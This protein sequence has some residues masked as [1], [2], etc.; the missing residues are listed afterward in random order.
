MRPHHILLP[1]YNY[2][3][4]ASF[5]LSWVFLMV[6]SVPTQTSS[7]QIRSKELPFHHVW[8]HGGCRQ[9]EGYFTKNSRWKYLSTP[10]SATSW[11]YWNSEMALNRSPGPHQVGGASNN[12]WKHITYLWNILDHT[13]GAWLQLDTWCYCGPS[14]LCEHLQ[15]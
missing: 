3:L 14:Y 15:E 7:L 2:F 11:S 5:L 10:Y 9:C 13:M 6:W 12:S 1:Y 4:S 8:R